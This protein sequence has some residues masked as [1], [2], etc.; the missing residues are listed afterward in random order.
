MAEDTCWIKDEHGKFIG[1]RPGCK[2]EKA[3][4][5]IL[6]AKKLSATNPIPVR[7]PK[8]DDVESNIVDMERRIREIMNKP[9][10]ERTKEEKELLDKYLRAKAAELGIQ[11]KD[12]MLSTVMAL[13]TVPAS[14][15]ALAAAIAV[16]TASGIAMDELMRYANE[17]F[18]KWGPAGVMLAALILAAAKGKLSKIAR[19]AE[20]KVRAAV[21][22][23]KAAGEAA[24]RA[25]E[26]GKIYNESAN[27]SSLSKSDIEKEAT[28]LNTGDVSADEAKRVNAEAQKKGVTIDI[29]GYKTEASQ[30][31]IEHSIR[32]HSDA[33][34][35]IAKAREA[36]GEKVSPQDKIPEEQ[37]K[38]NAGKHNVPLKKED[39]QNIEKYRRE[40][41]N[42]ESPAKGRVVFQPRNENKKF[43]SVDYQVQKDGEVIHMIYKIDHVNNKLTFVTMYKE[44]ERKPPEF[45]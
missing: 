30:D 23:R 25:K 15:T 4:S 35:E 38:G 31:R 14:A 2:M 44:T 40:A 26:R 20:G 12:Q 21:A 45:R 16:A 36:R 24:K 37:R 7:E 17:K 42:P 6:D 28:K 13:L 32:G 18:G 34:V 22:E 3:V 19:K 41:V 27:G 1:R 33:K 39:Y 8:G 10:S 43:E 5:G 9:E 11:W 29:T